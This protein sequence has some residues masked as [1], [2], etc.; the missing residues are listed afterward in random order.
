MSGAVGVPR[1]FSLKMT[2]FCEDETFHHTV[3]SHL[4]SKSL[5]N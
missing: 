2:L 4:I 3:D 5:F 1:V